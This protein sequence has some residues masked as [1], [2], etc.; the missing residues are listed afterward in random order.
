MQNTFLTKEVKKMIDNM[1]EI[2]MTFIGSSIIASIISSVV[3]ISSS[4]KQAS[5]G[6]ITKEHSQW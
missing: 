3:T 2:I 1:L 4:A 6:Y 5:S